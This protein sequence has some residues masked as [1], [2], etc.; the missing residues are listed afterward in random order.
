[1][2][3]KYKARQERWKILWNI[4]NG[5]VRVFWADLFARHWTRK[6]ECKR[7]SLE[8][9]DKT[10]TDSVF[11]GGLWK[12]A[13]KQVQV[14]VDCC[15]LAFASNEITAERP[16]TAILPAAGSRLQPSQQS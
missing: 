3:S 16:T 12:L 2:R 7:D 5:Q 9:P 1:M 13:R 15:G 6:V 8:R 4:S 14:S 10:L 11:I